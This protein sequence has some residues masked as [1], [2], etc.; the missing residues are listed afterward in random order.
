MTSVIDPM[1]SGIQSKL[2]FED[3]TSGGETMLLAI[4]KIKKCD[5]N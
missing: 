1:V 2:R 3:N 4:C 5:F